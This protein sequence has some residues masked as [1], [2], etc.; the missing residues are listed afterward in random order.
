MVHHVIIY[1]MSPIVNE[2]YSTKKFIFGGVILV[3]II[4]STAFILKKVV[5]IVCNKFR[6]IER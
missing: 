6:I 5:D 2:N 3:F 1:D 4:I